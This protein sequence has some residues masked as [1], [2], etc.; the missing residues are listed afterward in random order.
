MP[1]S[2]KEAKSILQDVASIIY[3]RDSDK[4]KEYGPFDESMKASAEVAS[5]LTGKDLTTK[6]FFLC[7]VAL[8]L[9]RLR[10][11]NKRDTYV[12]LVAYITGCQEL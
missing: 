1:N 5:I 2:K 3:N 12:D 7:M 9:T 6:D 8:K 10:Y 11:S 4:A